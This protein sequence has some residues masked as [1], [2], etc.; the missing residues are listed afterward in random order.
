MA[1]IAICKAIGV[2][3]NE[4]RSGLESYRGVKRRFEYMLDQEGKVFIDD[5]AHHPTEIEACISSV[6]ELYPNKKLT[7]AFQPHL[8]SR[9]RDFM[10]GFADSLSLADEVI[11]VPIYPAREKP[12]Q[13]VTSELLLDL[14]AVTNKVLCEKEELPSLIAARDL[15]VLLTLGAGDID[16]EIPLI[17]NHL[18]KRLKPKHN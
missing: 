6:R 15:E 8:F 16:R 12:I 2:G 10:S 13:G 1:A 4:I 5:Y 14:I 11:L 17:Q 7:V 18:T 3:E 9:T